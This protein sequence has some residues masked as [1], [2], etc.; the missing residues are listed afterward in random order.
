MRRISVITAL[1][2][3]FVVNGCSSGSVRS[4]PSGSP[5]SAPRPSVALTASELGSALGTPSTIA[6][7]STAA[8]LRQRIALVDSDHTATVRAVGDHLE[9]R[10][11]TTVTASLAQLAAVGRLT[12]RRVI[13]AAPA[14]PGSVT[15]GGDE[16]SPVVYQH[17]SCGS[18]KVD[19]AAT[20]APTRETVACS[21]EGS[22]K[23]HLGVAEVVGTDI[24][25]VSVGTDQN[26]ILIQV[27]FTGK[28]Q[29]KFTKL[30]EK[31]LN[32]RVAVD[33]DGVVYS[34]PTIRGVISSDAQITGFTNAQAKS[35][36]AVL[37]Y[38]A[39]PVSLIVR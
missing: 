15:S 30:T 13:E 5:S 32:K 21:K 29:T 19:P 4:H 17:L 8:V 22:E 33:F 1:L 35:L 2:S 23:F 11:S 39:L 36:A 18:T 14:T 28:G 25:G 31:T 34:A 38:G 16:Y 37:R 12:F 7:G 27:Q 26:G 10:A 20:E 24:K 9:V 6:L 3:V